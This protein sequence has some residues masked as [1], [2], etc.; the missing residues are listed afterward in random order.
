MKDVTFQD[1]QKIDMRVGT[2]LT[3]IDFE[4]ARNP[5]FILTIDFGNEIGILKSSAQL[6]E[7]YFEKNIIGKQIIAVVNFPNKQIADI[8]S[9]CLVLAV[10]GDEN[11]TA[12]LK[13]DG[14]VENGLRVG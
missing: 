6:K 3:A 14:V 7:R 2:I 13:I 5:A 1:F 4:K 11:G 10:V 9:Q 8:K 12:L